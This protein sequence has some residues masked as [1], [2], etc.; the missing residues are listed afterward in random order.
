MHLCMLTW[1]AILHLQIYLSSLLN[2]F[3]CLIHP[4]VLSTLSVVPYIFHLMQ[5]L[6]ISSHKYI[7]IIEDRHDIIV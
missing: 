4:F 2:F 3:L 7:I 5:W 1:N 6:I